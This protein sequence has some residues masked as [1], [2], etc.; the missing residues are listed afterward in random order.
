MCFSS[1][2]QLLVSCCLST[3]FFY[4]YAL[5]PLQQYWKS[6]IEKAGGKVANSV[7]GT[8]SES[9]VVYDTVALYLDTK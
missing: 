7:M 4:V 1:L 5:C 6:K 8:Y 2:T 3:D 9:L